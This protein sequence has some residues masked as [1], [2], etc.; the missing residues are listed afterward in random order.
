MNASRFD[1]PTQVHAGGP[2]PS[3]CDCGHPAEEHDR[4]AQRFCAAT[5]ASQLARG[6]VCVPA[7]SAALDRFTGRGLPH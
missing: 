7:V 5:R 2:V 1:G 6:C 4:V 3:A